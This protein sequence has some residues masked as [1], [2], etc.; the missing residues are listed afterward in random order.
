MK[1]KRLLLILGVLLALALGLGLAVQAEVGKSASGIDK[2]LCAEKLRFGIEAYQRG[3]YS[4]A[5][6]YF[7]E[8]I[9]A[10]PTNQRAW[11]YYDLSIMYDVAEQV[12]RAGRVVTS[13][14]PAPG[15][16]PWTEKAPAAASTPAPAPAPAPVKKGGIVIDD[17]GC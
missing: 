4:Q 13:S 2:K 10:D 16:A 15:S 5:K 1:S 9:Q 7:K 17:E 3:R 11:S 6:A 14:A 12:K 8:A